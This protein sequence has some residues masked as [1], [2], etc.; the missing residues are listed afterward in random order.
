MNNHR[1]DTEREAA[2]MRRFAT[3]RHAEHDSPEPMCRKCEKIALYEWARQEG[4]L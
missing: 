1:N 4:L 3:K 2:A